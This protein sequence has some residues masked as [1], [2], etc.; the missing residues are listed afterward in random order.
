MAAENE[1]V[2]DEQQQ[3]TVGISGSGDRP[4]VAEDVFDFGKAKM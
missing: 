4:D 1:E 2:D 3:N